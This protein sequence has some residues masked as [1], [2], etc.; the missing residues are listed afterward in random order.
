M[1]WR[2]RLL[3]AWFGPRGLSSLL[4]V[5]LP[6]FVG[7]PGSDR[8]FSLTCAVVLLSI[9]LHGGSLM[10]LGKRSRSS[11]P[12]QAVVAPTPPVP[13]PSARGE[14][15]FGKDLISIEEMRRIRGSGAPVILLDARTDRS[16][17]GNNENA[18]GAIRFL[19]DR[20]AE[21]QATALGLPRDALLIPFCACPND[22]TAVRVA[23]EL[24]EAGWPRARAL[25]GGWEAWK[26][27]GLPTVER[28]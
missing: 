16:Y 1:A 19:P 3:I 14:E 28:K 17:E 10:W 18:E 27:S 23:Q 24:R 5:L 15:R 13:V 6:V 9:V 25:D 8:L 11:H 7:L 26:K 20:A 22:E 12:P 2:D 4:L 21:P